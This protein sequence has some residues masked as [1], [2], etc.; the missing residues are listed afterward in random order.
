[1]YSTNVFPQFF[2][3]ATFLYH[4]YS[5]LFS[6]FNERRS[7][8]PPHD[9]RENLIETRHESLRTVLTS[10]F[11]KEFF[12]NDATEIDTKLRVT[13]EIFHP[14]DTRAKCT[15]PNELINAL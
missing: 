10:N 4:I 9:F 8:R 1:M 6:K 14:Y 13:F 2:K 3:I 7:K 12:R 11:C 5:L 15:I